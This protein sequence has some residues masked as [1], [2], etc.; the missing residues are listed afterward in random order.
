MILAQIGTLEFY[1]NLDRMHY[2]TT[3]NKNILAVFE[4]PKTPSFQFMVSETNPVANIMIKRVEIDLITTMVHETSVATESEGTYTRIKYQGETLTGEIAN[5][6]YLFHVKMGDIDYYSD[7]FSWNSNS[8]QLSELLKFSISCY[9]FNQG[10]SPIYRYDTENFSYE[11]YLI[12]SQENKKEGRSEEDANDLN[13]YILPYYSGSSVMRNI[14]VEINRNLYNLL[15]HLRTILVN[16]ALTLSY[17]GNDYSVIDFSTEVA[18]SSAD[19]DIVYL[20]IKFVANNDIITPI[21]E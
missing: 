17:R 19:F 16:G 15:F 7:V 6:H 20:E 4:N 12:V 9:D 3:G 21:N 2:Y 18:S 8:S 1:P 14:L 11:F 5:G 10:K 13:G